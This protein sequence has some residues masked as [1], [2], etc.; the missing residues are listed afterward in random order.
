MKRIL[1]YIL[2]LSAALLVPT[3]GTDVGRL[4]PVEVVALYMDGETIIIETDTED[5]GAGKTVDEAMDNL[6]DTTAGIIYLDTADYLLIEKGT[7]RLI[8]DIGE[9]LDKKVRVCA[10]EERIDFSDTV[11]FLSVHQPNLKLGEWEIGRSLQTLKPD[12]EKLMLK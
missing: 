12:G 3:G 7:E 10:I 8:T 2:I 1:L 11:E 4:R 9:H 5:T 6:K